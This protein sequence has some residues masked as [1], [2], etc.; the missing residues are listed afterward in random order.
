MKYLYFI[1]LLLLYNCGQAQYP[2]KFMYDTLEKGDQYIVESNLQL[3]E[4]ISSLDISCNKLKENNVYIIL[5]C[6]DNNFIIP[7]QLVT[8]ETKAF[9]QNT[10][11][12]NK[13]N[14]TLK[15]KEQL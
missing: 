15:F 13:S 4:S 12:N 2:I 11:N 5:M 6:S 14:N 8:L 7:K 3:I 10:V 9:L 1:L